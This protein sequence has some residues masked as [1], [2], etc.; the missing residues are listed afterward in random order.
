MY[1]S[2][3]APNL[4]GK[5]TYHPWSHPDDSTKRNAVISSII[6]LLALGGAQ[7]VYYTTVGA[8]R[9]SGFSQPAE[10]ISKNKGVRDALLGRE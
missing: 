4:V 10:Y 5:A 2:S 7:K 8:G 9:V 6:G 3:E 1:S